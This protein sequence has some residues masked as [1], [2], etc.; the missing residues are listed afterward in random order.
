MKNRS[1]KRDFTDK[2]FT[3]VILVLFAVYLVLW[4]KVEAAMPRYIVG[5]ALL[6]VALVF[7]LTDMKLQKKEKEKH[8]ENEEPKE[9]QEN[10]EN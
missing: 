4:L 10:E 2:I 9:N 1:N 5:A 6:I 7:K 8:I 3:A